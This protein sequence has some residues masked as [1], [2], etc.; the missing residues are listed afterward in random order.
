MSQMISRSENII[1]YLVVFLV[2]VVEVSTFFRGID[3]IGPRG[4]GVILV[5]ILLIISFSRRVEL[6]FSF[7][8]LVILIALLIFIQGV[9]FGFSVVTVFTYIIFGVTISY[10]TYKIVGEKIFEYLVDVIFYTSVIAT[11]IWVLQVL[12]P[13]VDYF[14][15]YLRVSTPTP[16][17]EG[18]VGSDVNDRVN[19]ALLYTIPHWTQ[20]IFG[21]EVLRNAGMFHEPGAFAYFIILALGLNTIIQK[22]FFNVRNIILIV[23]LLTTF[24]TAGYLS[25]IVL[26]FY[27]VMNANIYTTVKLVTVPVFIIVAFLSY[28]QFE[29]LEEKLQIH[30]TTQIEGDEVYEGTGGRIRRVRSAVNLLTTSPFIGRGIITA[31]RD[32]ELGSPYYFTGAG[33]WRTLSSYGILFAPIIFFLYYM[34]I[35]A[36]CNHYQFHK[37]FAI[38]FFIAIALGA[39]SQRFFMDNVTMILLIHGLITIADRS[40]NK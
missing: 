14:L 6:N 20:N 11:F 21:V 17:V 31:S 12:I 38:V 16:L 1:N 7:L 29:F 34:G 26:L 27:A 4:I 2:L 39:S 8:Y 40:S 28:T 24:S 37:S 22:S 5:V 9:F 30:Y 18:Q 25:L 32:F 33:I 13:P 23:V 15:Q 3:A 36:N 10:L 19:I 35:R